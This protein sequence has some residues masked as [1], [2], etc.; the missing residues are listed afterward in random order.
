[1][2]LKELKE[3]IKRLEN[4]KDDNEIAHLLEDDLREIVLKEITKGNPEGQ[5]LAEE[6]LKTSKINFT[7]WYA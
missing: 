1:M 3:K 7:R 5:K 6:V 4:M 2:T